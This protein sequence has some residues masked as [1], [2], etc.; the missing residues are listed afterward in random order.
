MNGTTA[1]ANRTRESNKRFSQCDRGILDGILVLQTR[2]KVKSADRLFNRLA[3]F[4]VFSPRYS[5]SFRIYTVSLAS[6]ISNRVKSIYIYIY[7]Y[8]RDATSCAAR[9]HYRVALH[10]ISRSAITRGEWTEK[11]SVLSTNQTSS[12]NRSA[13]LGYRKREDRFERERD[14]SKAWTEERAKFV[15]SSRTTRPSSAEIGE[16]WRSRVCR[17]DDGYTALSCRVV[18]TCAEFVQASPRE[19]NSLPLACLRF[20]HGAA[21]LFTARTLLHSHYAEW[22]WDGDRYARPAHTRFHRMTHISFTS[23]VFRG[24]QRVLSACARVPIRAACVLGHMRERARART[25]ALAVGTRRRYP[26]A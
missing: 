4:L 18:S 24:L 9:K 8:V 3:A 1:A 6:T 25:P 2:E 23:L 20:F 15:G 7:T 11:Q 22:Q 16:G 10:P 19:F 14:V 5:P 12:Q 13:Y 21:S 26:T 17:D